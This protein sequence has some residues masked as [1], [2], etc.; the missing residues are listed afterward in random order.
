MNRTSLL[1]WIVSL[2]AALATGCGSP[3]AVP[4]ELPQP[5]YVDASESPVST[6]T[7]YAYDPEAM[8]YD[9]EFCKATRGGTC[10]VPTALAQGSPF[11]NLTTLTN[12][13]V[14]MKDPTAPVTTPPTPPVY[15]AA[16]TTATGLWSIDLP[17]RDNAPFFAT[18]TGVGAL[19][20]SLSPA[21]TANLPIAPLSTYFATMNLRPYFT[22]N[23]TA[24]PFGEAMQI[25]KDGVLDAVAK[26]LTSK[27]TT[28]AVTDFAIPTK[29]TAAVVFFVY[30]P[31]VL[32]NVP[33]ANPA[34]YFPAYNT[35]VKSSVGTSY[36][37]SWKM[38]GTGPAALQSKRG[39]YVDDTVTSSPLGIT[40]VLIPSVP[41]G[42]VAPGTPI[43]Y[44][45]T[46]T[47]VDSNAGRPYAWTQPPVPAAPAVIS[48]ISI[49]MNSTKP[50][51]NGSPVAA[52]PWFLCIN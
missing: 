19:P 6:V 32:P 44:T 41:A 2:G 17:A 47:V 34:V 29:Y 40:V 5:D 51:P 37:L 30:G 8:V 33:G 18:S 22:G 4:S 25:S 3:A 52:P 39:F 50:L 12:A 36:F 13:V 10:A 16:A 28:T 11:Y 48:A 21:V 15:V 27:G 26:Y 46:D 49:H 35:L 23:G 7:G 20:T 31:S 45:I 14:Y 9:L 38:P 24:C 43:N 42:G 1:G